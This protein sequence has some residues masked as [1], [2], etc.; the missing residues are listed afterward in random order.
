[1]IDIENK[2]DALQRLICLQISVQIIIR[3]YST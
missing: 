1:M 3:M 2:I